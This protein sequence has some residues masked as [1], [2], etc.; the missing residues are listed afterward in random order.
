MANNILSLPDG[1]D[2]SSF[3]YD[4]NQYYIAQAAYV[5]YANYR[6]TITGDFSRVTTLAAAYIGAHTGVLSNTTSNPPDTDY[7]SSHSY[8]DDYCYAYFVPSL[9]S[10]SLYYKEI[11]VPS[12]FSEW[13]R[14]N[15]GSYGS[16]VNPCFTYS[17]SQI[18]IKTDS[19]SMG[20][21][22]RVTSPQQGLWFVAL[23]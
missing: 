5:S 10:T 12:Y 18:T 4:W 17:S 23:R 6:F 2:L 20:G 9:R 1:L 14:P 7:R 8:D 21:S 11:G 13:V 15:Y 19:L 16:V 22:S 3:G